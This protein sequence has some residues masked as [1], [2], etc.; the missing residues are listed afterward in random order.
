MP[1]EPVTPRDLRG[2]GG[3]RQEDQDMS[4]DVAPIGPVDFDPPHDTTPRA[5]RA[6]AGDASDV[7]S[8]A[9]PASPPAEVL[10]AIGAAAQRH[11]ELLAQGRELRFTQD[12]AGG[13]HVEV[14]DGDGDVLRAIAPSEALDIATGASPD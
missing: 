5:S 6:S 14:L 3:R 12:E 4:L 11:G 13:V 2:A 9:I 10:D 1:E 8:D 7:S